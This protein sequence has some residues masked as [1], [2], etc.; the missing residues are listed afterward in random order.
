MYEAAGIAR[1][2]VLIKIA[3][4][5]EGIRAAE[6]L[7]KEGIHCNLTLLFGMHQAV[8]CAEAKV[9]LISPFV[10]RILDWYK[11]ATGATS[12]PPHEDPGVVSVT[13][14]YN[15][16]KKLRLQDRGHGRELPQHG[17]DHRA[18]RLRPAR[19]SRRSSS[20]SS[21]ADDGRRSRASSI[22]TKAKAMAIERI[23]MD[24][25][26]FRAM[27]AED[28]MAKEKLDEGIE[29]SPRR[30]RRS[31]SCSPSATTRCTTGSRRA[32]AAREFFK[33]YDLDGDGLITREEWAGSDG[34]VRRARRRPRRRITPR[35]WP[36]ASAPPT[37]WTRPDHARARQAPACCAPA[38]RCMVS[39]HGAAC[40]Y[41]GARTGTAHTSRTSAR[42]TSCI[43]N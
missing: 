4:T 36:P 40:M 23:A 1:E 42:M 10:G 22:P 26:I 6:V 31:R 8:A 35:S 12:Y 30:S 17:R 15:Y 43:G 27:H 32:S 41:G 11:K 2:R 7:E 37:T 21:Q 19:R 33:V 39:G 13:R 9:T 16:Y 34:G 38:C 20:P 28:R 5:W 29:G 24:E 18:R 25:A 14:I 3:S